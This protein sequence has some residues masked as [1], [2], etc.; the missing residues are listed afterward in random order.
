MLTNPYSMRRNDPLDAA[1]LNAFIQEH[2]AD[3]LRFK[4][5][6][7]QYLTKPPIFVK[8]KKDDYKPDNRLA[9]NFA[10][11]LV[12][13][14][15][16]YFIGIPP[17]IRHDNDAVNTA[18]QRF[19]RIN[20]VDNVLVELA[21]MTSLYGRAYLFV[22]QDEDAETRIAY[23]SPFDMF[24]IYDRGIKPKSLYGIRYAESEEGGYEGQIYETDRWFNF[25]LF[26]NELTLTT[27]DED[28][29]GAL[30][31]GRVP[32]IEFIENEERQSLVTPVEVLIN[33]YNKVLSEKSND[34]DYFSDAY[35]AVLGV[36]LDQKSL[37]TFRQNRILNIAGNGANMQGVDVK[38][39]DKP[40]A[41]AS[42]M[43]LL[44]LLE[45]NIYQTSMVTNL[46]ANR[47]SNLPASGEALKIRQQ[48]MANVSR[49]KELKF[50]ESLDTLF[51]MFFAL[52]TNIQPQN[53]RDYL[54]LQYTW[55]QN[56]LRNEKE[57]AE[58]AKM[59]GGIVSRRTQ[60]ER[61]SFIRDAEEE[62]DQIKAEK[63]EVSTVVTATAPAPVVETPNEGGN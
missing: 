58:I 17:R 60:L 9:V 12:D 28:N 16:G 46:N 40:D 56:I 50:Q 57:E 35:L 32:I 14:L 62:L 30:Y 25:H 36:Q 20:G 24:V 4:R 31:Y 21:K 59:L 19:W 48:P 11:Y 39:L 47:N 10:K 7:D 29:A 63:E 23:N 42:Q 27:P 34:I 26:G 55:T 54:D 49:V 13:T 15:N 44:E 3:K 61:L 22:Y 2:E 37:E 18:V 8:S 33:A 51:R 43:H 53:R 5:L 1:T 52:P 41:D 45:D 38:F 6:Q